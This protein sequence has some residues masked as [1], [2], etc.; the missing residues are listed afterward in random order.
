MSRYERFES[1]KIHRSE[2]RNA[3]YNPRK[4]SPQARKRLKTS[5]E[6]HGYVQPLVWNKRT[7]NLV[8]GHQRLDVLDQLEGSDDYSIT[9]AVIDV[10]LER[11]KKLNTILNNQSTMGYFD[12]EKLVKLLQ[13]N[14]DESLEAYGFSQ[15]DEKRLR[16]LMK[17]AEESESMIMA[18]M[19]EGLE[20]EDRVFDVTEEQERTREKERLSRKQA[21]EQAV[22]NL[23]TEKDD[24]AWKLKTDE[25]KKEFDSRRSSYRE[26]T[27]K[28]FSVK[29]SFESEASK[30]AWLNAR[31]LP[32]DRDTVHESEIGVETPTA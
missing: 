31:N 14:A 7:K 4:I 1:V 24:S 15:N 11:E 25:E 10:P 3:D 17:E 12:D 13:E 27:F 16:M 6:T 21:Y 29:I 26:E 9:V 19:Q 8:G 20:F 23:M 18:S 22:G 30:K 5:L 32:T 28:Y 2:L